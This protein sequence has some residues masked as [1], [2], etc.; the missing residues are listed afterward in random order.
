[1]KNSSTPLSHAV[2]DICG[3]GLA[4]FILRAFFGRRS[5][6]LPVSACVITM[7]FRAAQCTGAVSVMLDGNSILGGLLDRNAL[8]GDMIACIPPMVILFLMMDM[9]KHIC[10]NELPLK[11]VVIAF[12]ATL[13]AFLISVM[14]PGAVLLWLVLMI[15]I[16]KSGTEMG[17][18][19]RCGA[20]LFGGAFFAFASYAILEVQFAV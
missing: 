11:N 2:W 18:A 5:L 6:L 17:D 4:Y 12:V 20:Y 13:A 8:A 14:L 16:G 9:E 15:I 19:V 3:V 10:E 7:I 1:M